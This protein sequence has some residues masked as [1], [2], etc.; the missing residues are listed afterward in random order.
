MGFLAYDIETYTVIKVDELA[1][2]RAENERL[3]EQLNE[4]ATEI[5]VEQRGGA[6]M[7]IHCPVCDGCLV[8][9]GH[10]TDCTLGIATPKDARAALE[11]DKT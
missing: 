10:F 1:A 4:L 9:N 8:D 3:R 2:L 6:I 5:T 11:D 7:H